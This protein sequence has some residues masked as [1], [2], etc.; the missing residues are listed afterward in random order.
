MIKIALAALMTAVMLLP[1]CAF[2]ESYDYKVTIS[3]GDRG[4]LPGGLVEITGLKY[5]DTFSVND[6]IKGLKL[7]DNDT[8]YF[9]RGLKKAGKDN[10]DS[11]Y[12]FTSSVRV[13]KDTD[14][15]VA[16]GL[17]ANM[18]KYTVRYE[19]PDG[20]ELLPASTHYGNVG[21]KPV[22]AYMYV[23]GYQPQAYNL[24]KTLSANEAD[25]VLV[26][27]YTKNEAADPNNGGGG[28]NGSGA[29]AN[30]GS[31]GGTSP[32]N[33]DGN[34]AGGTADADNEGAAAVTSPDDDVPKQLINLDDGETPLANVQQEESK[35]TIW[36]IITGGIVAVLALMGILTLVLALIKRRREKKDAEEYYSN[37]A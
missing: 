1:V 9:V 2:G 35:S 11:P 7:K 16:Y 21:D 22:V 4:T 34:A 24:M 6:S 8:R 23:D 33:G 32:A 20:K 10:F 5:G 13:D 12:V 15:V 3:G 19:D 27:K 25:N 28:D 14:Y 31:G 36:P 18:V 29:P 17:K 30:G 26:F 37:Y